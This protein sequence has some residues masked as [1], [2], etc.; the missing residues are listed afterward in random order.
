MKERLN[1]HRRTVA[2]TGSLLA[3]GIILTPVAASATETSPTPSATSTAPTPEVTPPVTIDPTESASTEPTP[4]IVDDSSMT[5]TPEPTPILVDDSKMTPPAKPQ[6]QEL[7]KTGGNN[8][9]PVSEAVLAIGL[10]A[11][12][13][14][15]VLK[16]KR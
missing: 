4:I 10:I 3:T 16:T 6:K 11:A 2:L 13:S 7:A 14:T 1:N 8:A 12:G 5:P 15:I 9:A